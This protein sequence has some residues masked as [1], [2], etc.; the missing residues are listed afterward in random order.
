MVVSAITQ[1][2]NLYMQARV[3]IVDD[4]AVVRSGARALLESAGLDVC[5]ELDGLHALR[6]TV[7]RLRP[8]VVLLDVRLS[9]G[10]GISVV[11][12]LRAGPPPVNVVVFSAHENSIV[13]ARAHQA[14]ANAYLSKSASAS[15]F[16]DTLRRAARGESLWTHN[17][18][19][20]LSSYF[21][22]IAGAQAHDPPLT[23]RERQILGAI[24]AGDTNKEIAA[25]FQISAETVKEHIQHLFRKLGVSDRTQAAVLAIRSG[26][27]V[28]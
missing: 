28:E 17:D 1:R 2:L 13:E 12:E 19:R 11:A 6:E 10:D 16:V 23:P 25:R 22:L 9:D 24:V 4:H 21:K 20:R 14:G 5:G 27:K 26:F 3:L 18:L 8:E 7:E 15:E